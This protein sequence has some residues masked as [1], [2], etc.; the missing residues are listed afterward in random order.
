MLPKKQLFEKCKISQAK[1]TSDNFFTS[2][3]IEKNFS[4]KLFSSNVYYNPEMLVWNSKQFLSKSNIVEQTWNLLRHFT[5]TILLQKKKMRKWKLLHLETFLHDFCKSSKALLLILVPT[6]NFRSN[7]CMLWLFKISLEGAHIV[8]LSILFRYSDP[9]WKLVLL[10]NSWPT[11]PD[12][13]ENFLFTIKI[14]TR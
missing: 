10:N 9:L 13:F 14:L 2:Q 3:W 6:R 5:F 11:S 7:H 8:W 1:L 4:G 12:Q